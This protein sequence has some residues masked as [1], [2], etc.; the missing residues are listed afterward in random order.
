[1]ITKQRTLANRDE[2]TENGHVANLLIKSS[3]LTNF[4]QSQLSCT[5]HNNNMINVVQF[6]YF[7]NNIIYYT[8]FES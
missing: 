4:V 8:R 5:E 1:M 2:L 7:G 3:F 6:L